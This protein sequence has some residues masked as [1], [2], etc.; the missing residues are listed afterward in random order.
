MPYCEEQKADGKNNKQ[1]SFI[2]V[3]DN[4]IWY[5]ITKAQP[6]LF[7]KVV[8]KFKMAVKSRQPI[9]HIYRDL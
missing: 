8:L 2:V 3:Q 6:D 4:T 7:S 9:K 5:F 1:P